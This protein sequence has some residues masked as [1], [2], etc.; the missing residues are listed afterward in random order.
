MTLSAVMP[1]KF[2]LGDSGNRRH[3]GVGENNAELFVHQQDA[4]LGQFGNYIQLFLGFHPMADIS[5]KLKAANNMI[6]GISDNGGI[7]HHRDFI[8]GP[9]HHY[10]ADS[11]DRQTGFHGVAQETF[12]GM[13]NLVV[14]RISAQ[15]MGPTT[16]LAVIT[17]ELFHGL[18]HLVIM[19]FL[20]TKK[21]GVGKF[22]RMLS[23]KAI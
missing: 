22:F 5:D 6:V 11:G 20:S 17:G 13:R 10:L 4:F 21:K 12:C 7:D 18:V 3:F 8:A 14:H 23:S 9:I 19:R 1:I 2:F 16:S 15:V